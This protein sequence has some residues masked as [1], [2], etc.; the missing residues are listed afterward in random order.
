MLS[1]PLSL[2]HTHSLT[3]THTLSLSLSISL[4][5]SLS[6]RLS[7]NL[8]QTL[9]LA[10]AVFLTLFRG[11]YNISTNASLGWQVYRPKN[12][13]DDLA[14]DE[15]GVMDATLKNARFKVNNGF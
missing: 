11:R 2:T 1:L 13:A 5:P 10:L 4:S 14:Q 7:Q 9:S 12:N 3:L 8:F 15:E 6:P